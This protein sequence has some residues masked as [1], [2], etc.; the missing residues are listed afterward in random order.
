[1]SLLL[2]RLTLVA[3]SGCYSPVAVLRLLVAVASL[4]AEHRL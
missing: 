4:I 3:A 2:C 1:M